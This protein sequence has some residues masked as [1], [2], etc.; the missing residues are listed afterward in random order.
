MV[1]INPFKLQSFNGSFIWDEIL[2][3]SGLTPFSVM[4]RKLPS[5]TFNT[6]LPNFCCSSEL[7]AMT[8]MLI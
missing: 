5:P 3:Q 1:M 7:A 4:A 8:R 2:I 6:H